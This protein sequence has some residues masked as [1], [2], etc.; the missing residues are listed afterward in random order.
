MS[1][2][3][4]QLCYPRTWSGPTCPHPKVHRTFCYWFR[5]FCHLCARPGTD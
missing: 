2:A 1:R 3:T 4:I 5:G